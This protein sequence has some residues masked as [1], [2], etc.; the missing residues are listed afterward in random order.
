MATLLISETLG[1]VGLSPS[2][3][4]MLAHLC[5]VRCETLRRPANAVIFARLTDSRQYGSQS[6]IES[7]AGTNQINGILHVIGIQSG[8][9]M[10]VVSAIRNSQGNKT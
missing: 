2:R 8:D 3:H 10:M 7:D 9:M 4:M 1:E 5:V 6:Q